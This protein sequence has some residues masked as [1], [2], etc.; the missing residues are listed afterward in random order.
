MKAGIIVES[1]S[2][3]CSP[4]VPVRKKDGSVRLCVD[5]RELNSI[6]PLRRHWIP[7]LQEILDKI[8]NCVV[9]SKLD[10]TSGFHQ[11]RVEENSRELTTF[12]CPLGSYKYLRMPFGLKNARLFSRQSWKRCCAQF[13]MSAT[14]ILMTSLF[15]VVAGMTILRT[16]GMSGQGRLED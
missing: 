12:V 6:T 15:I 14:T 7:T 8:G 1:S 13:L 11:I 5:Y 2:E 3:W 4:L 9:L 10:L 16:S